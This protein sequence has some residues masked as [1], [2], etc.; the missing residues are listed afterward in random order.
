MKD[1][2]SNQQ[3]EILQNIDTAKTVK[4][5]YKLL[6]TYNAYNILLLKAKQ[7]YYGMNYAE[8]HYQEAECYRKIKTDLFS[9][10]ADNEY[11]VGKWIDD[12]MIEELLFL[13]DSKTILKISI[14]D[15]MQ[16]ISC[17]KI[18]DIHYKLIDINDCRLK[19][20][21]KRIYHRDP[22]YYDE[23]YENHDACSLF[24]DGS[25]ITQEY[26]L[27]DNLLS[28]NNVDIREI[29]KELSIDE[30]HEK[31]AKAK[32]CKIKQLTLKY[33]EHLNLKR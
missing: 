22:Y 27:N 21:P 25:I 10:F 9:L 17:D 24:N 8:K 19:I 5:I 26:V 6:S 7:H 33:N 31:I 29:L 16:N 32:D 2:L 1:L 3:L 28:C 12:P 14:I 23:Y 13:I 15:K 18:S 30:I 11:I 4:E 20:Y